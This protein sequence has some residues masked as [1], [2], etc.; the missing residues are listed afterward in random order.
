MSMKTEGL[1][2]SNGDLT[3]WG[4]PSG[5]PSISVEWKGQGNPMGGD[6]RE[7]EDGSYLW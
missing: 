2:V 4:R 7:W 5:I 3:M 6:L 1:I